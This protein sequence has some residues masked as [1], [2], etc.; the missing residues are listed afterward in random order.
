MRLSIDSM[1]LVRLLQDEAMID[2]AELIQEDKIEAV[3]SPLAMVEVYSVLAKRD[4]ARAKSYIGSLWASKLLIP[5]LTLSTITLS[6][7]LKNEYKLHLADAIIAATGI[8]SEAKHILTDDAHFK[9]VRKRIKPINLKQCKNMLL[10][11]GLL[12]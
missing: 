3:V 11:E 9:S 5:G 4:K 1:Y 8:T 2:L 10:K 12:R 7:D 6:G